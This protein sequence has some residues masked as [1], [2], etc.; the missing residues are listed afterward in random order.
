MK[1]IDTV[2]IR[3]I[4]CP[5]CGYE[6]KAGE[7]TGM[8]L[9]CPVIG[10]N[11]VSKNPPD[12]L[13]DPDPGRDM[14]DALAGGLRFTRNATGTYT[15]T[16][17]R[18]A[19]D[20]VTVPESVNGM[21]VTGIGPKAFAA[22]V[23][24]RRVTLP[25]TVATIGMDA[26]AG[27]TELDTVVFGKGLTLLDQGC[28]RGCTKLDFV[29]LPAKVEEIGRDAFAGCESL[30]QVELQGQ[31]KRIRD[32]AFSLCIQLRSFRCAAR[33]VTAVDGAFAGCYQLPQEVRDQILGLQ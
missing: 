16:S 11:T 29:V 22:Q 26:F 25:D 31:V 21:A 4:R 3:R 13:P 6:F 27:C 20:E 24:L 10:C 9:Q 14:V 30:V 7:L 28:F 19:P 5:G 32:G 33:P 2:Q 23:Q 17:V 18:G 8:M 1:I 15:L 12:V